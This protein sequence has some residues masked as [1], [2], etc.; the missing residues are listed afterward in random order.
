MYFFY[1][2]AARCKNEIIVEV[3]YKKNFFSL[4]IILEIYEIIVLN[5]QHILYNLI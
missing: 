5:L 2:K 3:V 1:E 4:Q